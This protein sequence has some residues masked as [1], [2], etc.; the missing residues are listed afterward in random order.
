MTYWI[1]S[2]V[3]MSFL[4]PFM[5]ILDCC[6]VAVSHT[7]KTLWNVGNGRKGSLQ[8]KKLFKRDRKFCRNIQF[9]IVSPLLSLRR[10]TFLLYLLTLRAEWLD[11]RFKTPSCPA[12]LSVG[13]GAAKSTFIRDSDSLAN[14]GGNIL[15]LSLNKKCNAF[16]FVTKV[17]RC[18]VIYNLG[19]LQRSNVILL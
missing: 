6:T 18:L 19:R 5:N 10:S 15:A 8:A 14:D 13:R 17:S 7:Q 12:G 16:Y 2:C 1:N 9:M 11:C 3:W 4:G